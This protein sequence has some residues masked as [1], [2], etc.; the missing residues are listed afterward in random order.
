MPSP[1]PMNGILADLL[2]KTAC[3]TDL[4]ISAWVSGL[5]SMSSA[6]VFCSTPARKSCFS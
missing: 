4:S 5:F 2:E 3:P 6:N 1:A